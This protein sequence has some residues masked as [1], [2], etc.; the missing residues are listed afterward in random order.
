MIYHITNREAWQDA[1][2]RGAYRAPSL[3]AD[4]FIHCSAREQVLGVANDFYRGRAN[5][6][7]LC[8]DER[9]LAAKLRWDTPIH[10]N[11]SASKQ[12]ATESAFPHVYGELNL[13]AVVTAIEFR[14]GETGFELPR[15]LP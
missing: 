1:R 7:L 3:A 10:P 12:T 15:K 11:P 6:L 4:G 9:K 2:E 13:D 8:I 5:L 14:E